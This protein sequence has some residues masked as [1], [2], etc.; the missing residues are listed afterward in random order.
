[1]SRIPGSGQRLH[2]GSM[3][4]LGS[5]HGT[6]RSWKRP[7]AAC[8]LTLGLVVLI[9]AAV[10]NA[11]AIEQH[12]TPPTCIGLGL[13]CTPDAV[14]TVVLGGMFVGVPVPSV[15]WISIVAG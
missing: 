6:G 7:I 4:P 10:G 9:L 13:G 14:T 5:D 2:R 8:L 12:A 3:N 11:T 15:A 1:M